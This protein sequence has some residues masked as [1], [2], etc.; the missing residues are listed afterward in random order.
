MSSLESSGNSYFLRMVLR[1]C[2]Q[3][4]DEFKRIGIICLNAPVGGKYVDPLQCVYGVATERTV[5]VV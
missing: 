3:G 2:S 4:Q 1:A 5:T